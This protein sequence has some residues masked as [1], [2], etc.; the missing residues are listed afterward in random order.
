M[1]VLLKTIDQ[2]NLSKSEQYLQRLA[3]RTLAI[4]RE[5]LENDWAKEESK[6]QALA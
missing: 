5:Y 6:Y 1:R 4:R 2:P 3:F